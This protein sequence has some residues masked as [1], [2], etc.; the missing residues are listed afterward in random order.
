MSE[1]H[2]LVIMKFFQSA[3]HT[4]GGYRLNDEKFSTCGPFFGEIRGREPG[5]LSPTFLD[6]PL[7]TVVSRNFPFVWH[8]SFSFQNLSVRFY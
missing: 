6:L 5:P 3:A 4:Y 2:T 8:L 1:V 7:H